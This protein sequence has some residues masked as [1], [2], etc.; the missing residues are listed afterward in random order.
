MKHSL[1]RLL[2]VFVASVAIF[3][4]TTVVSPSASAATCNI[5]GTYRPCAR[6]YKYPTPGVTCVEE[7]YTLTVGGYAY[8]GRCYGTPAGFYREYR[9]RE[10]IQCL[11]A[12]H[13]AWS[14][15]PWKYDGSWSYPYYQCP[16]N[17]MAEA[18]L[19]HFEWL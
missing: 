13:P 16:L 5:N 15:G 3:G 14:Y 4:L 12:G 2:S 17:A 9:Y 7:Q 8:R 19:L 11:Y 6:W 18:H 1:S 10:E